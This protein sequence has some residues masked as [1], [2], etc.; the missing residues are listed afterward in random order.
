[1]LHAQ[2][3]DH[4]MRSNLQVG[5][6]CRCAQEGPG[7]RASEPPTAGHLGVAHSFVQPAIEVFTVR[8]TRLL[9]GLDE[10]MGRPENGAV[11]FYEQFA[12]TPAASR[13]TSS[14]KASAPCGSSLCASSSRASAVVS[15]LGAV[16]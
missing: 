13:I 3:G 12:I 16:P 14:S 7:G 2:P 4:T 15:Q 9:R 8:V 1:M 5:P 6:P 11:I 10:T